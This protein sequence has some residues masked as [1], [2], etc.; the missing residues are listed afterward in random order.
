[1]PHK[2]KKAAE[3]KALQE[4]QTTAGKK[5]VK[6]KLGITAMKWG[7]MSYLQKPSGTKDVQALKLS[8]TKGGT[9]K[10]G[11]EASK[12]TSE[13]L[14]SIGQA[15]YNPK[16][17]GYVLTSKGKE[18]QYGISGGAMG[19]GDPTGIMSSIPI[20]AKMHETQKVI[21]G[22]ALG[23][24][25]LVFP[26]TGIGALGG[27]MARSSAADAFK[28]KGEE[29]Y[30]KYLSKFRTKQETVMGGKRATLTGGKTFMT[31]EY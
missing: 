7:P 4:S 10:F 5:Y 11:E 2:S 8:G 26:Q 24:M 19:S 27:F 13:Y 20:S 31:E 6:E 1:M 23:A 28:S 16:T 9:K 3:K 14:E 21:Q 29:G 25:S 18:M 30:K 17:G 15:V 22:I 12:A